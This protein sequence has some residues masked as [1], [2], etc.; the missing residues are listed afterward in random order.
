MGECRG[1]ALDTEEAVEMTPPSWR[2]CS[3]PGTAACLVVI[4]EEPTPCRVKQRPKKQNKN[5]NDK[6]NPS[7]PTHYFVVAF[8]AFHFG[9]S[10]TKSRVG[11]ELLTVAQ[12]PFQ[13]EV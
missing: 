13:V 1:C 7:E 6:T 2:S 12:I 3:G 5:N 11:N 8:S 10:V 4:Q 9:R